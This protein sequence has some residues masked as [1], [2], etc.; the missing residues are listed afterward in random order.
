MYSRTL[1]MVEAS[2]NDVFGSG[3]S[4][5][6]AVERYEEISGKPT[7]PVNVT[8]SSSAKWEA[9]PRSRSRVSPNPSRAKCTSRRPMSC[10]ITRAACS[11]LSTPS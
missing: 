8:H 11:T 7:R 5:I 4:P 3:Q 9:R 2:L 6:D 1:F 10:T